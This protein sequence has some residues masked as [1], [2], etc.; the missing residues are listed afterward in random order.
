[1]PAQLIITLT[2]ENQI[3]ISGPIQNKL[4]CYGMMCVAMDAMRESHEQNKQLI[5]PATLIPPTNIGN[6]N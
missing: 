1:M 5:Q 4:L 6:K 2:D 3:N